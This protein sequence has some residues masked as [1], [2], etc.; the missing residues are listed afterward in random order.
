MLIAHEIEVMDVFND[1]MLIIITGNF[2]ALIHSSI[3]ENE[4]ISVIDNKR[5]LIEQM[6][7]FSFSKVSNIHICYVSVF[8]NVNFWIHLTIDYI[9]FVIKHNILYKFIAALSFSKY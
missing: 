9:T 2:S 6:L 7:K 1:M 8:Y 5:L 3:I 4:F